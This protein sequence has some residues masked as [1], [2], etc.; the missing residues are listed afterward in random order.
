M[1]TFSYREHSRKT[2]IQCASF[3]R[4]L[5]LFKEIGEL[6][7]NAGDNFDVDSGHWPTETGIDRLILQVLS[8]RDDASGASNTNAVPQISKLCCEGECVGVFFIPT[9]LLRLGAL[10][11]LTH[12]AFMLTHDTDW[13]YF[14]DVVSQTHLTLKSL[15]I[16]ILSFSEE[17][18][19]TFV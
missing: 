6:R 4:F 1:E 11:N 7:V 19:C 8:A 17:G 13:D 2:S 14:F 5:A 3:A 15:N 12:L 10:G 16:E 18:A 9:Y